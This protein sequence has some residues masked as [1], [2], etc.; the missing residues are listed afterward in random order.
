MRAETVD[1]FYNLGNGRRTA[2]KELAE[3]LLRLTGSRQAIEYASRSQAT[4]VCNRI[5]SPERAKRE[6][7]FAA[8]IGL[9]DGLRCLIDWRNMNEARVRL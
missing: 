4:L 6:I 7:G 3:L 9:E 8:S 1:C 2:L 5:G